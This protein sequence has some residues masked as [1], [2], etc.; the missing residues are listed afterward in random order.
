[1]TCQYH[2]GFPY[3]PVV[4][5]LELKN[6]DLLYFSGDQIYEQNGGYPIKREPEDVAILKLPG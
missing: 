1:M 4:R 5:N 2:T 3:A 6:P